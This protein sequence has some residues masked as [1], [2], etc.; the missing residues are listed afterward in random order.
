MSDIAALQSLKRNL[1][2]KSLNGSVFVAATSAASIDASSLFAAS[3]GALAA[4]GLPSTAWTDLGFTTDAG[5][6]WAQSVTKSEVTSWQSTSPTRS[7]TTS[8]VTTLQLACQETK[9][10][11]IASYVGI[12][13]ATIKTTAAN[14]VVEIAEALTPSAHY[15]RVLSI[16]VDEQDT[17]EFV[18]CR[19][20][21]NATVTAIDNQSFAKQ[22]DPAL[23]G[24]TYTGYPDDTLGYA[25]KWIFGGPG[26][27]AA[28]SAMGFTLGT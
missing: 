21:P 4:A 28:I 25:H 22:D 6:Q 19:Y 16:A 18:I 26:W 20:M 9:L 17:G 7:D 14:G 8:K 24:L 12:D 23:W 15:Q 10:A 2:R 5:A 3:T 11:T 13:A 27:K 1:I